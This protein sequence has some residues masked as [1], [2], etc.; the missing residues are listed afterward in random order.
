MSARLIFMAYGPY[1]L[2]IFP[3]Y[4]VGKKKKKCRVLS[5]T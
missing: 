3:K 4:A 5:V 1:L 2:Y